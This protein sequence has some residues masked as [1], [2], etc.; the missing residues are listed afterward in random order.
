MILLA[1]DTSGKNGS[2]ALARVDETAINATSEALEVLELVP[3]EGGTFSAQLVPQISDL[4]KNQGL[5]KFD[6]GG[7]AV[8]SGP[9][10][11]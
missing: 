3:L 6:I 4:L 9:V 1:A 11:P 2:L 8:V 7:F 10:H 5:T